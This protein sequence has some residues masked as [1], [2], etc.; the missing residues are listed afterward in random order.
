MNVSAE[1][2]RS[3]I[4]QAL[5]MDGIDFIVVTKSY[6]SQDEPSFAYTIGLYSKVGFELL[7]IG[8]DPLK[9]GD[10]IIATMAVAVI[11]NDVNMHDPHHWDTT[12]KIKPLLT[13]LCLPFKADSYVDKAILYHGES[14][15][16]YQIVVPDVLGN[17]PHEFGY[18]MPAVQ[19]CLYADR[20]IKS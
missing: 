18:L 9:G 6:E 13:K 3:Q 12:E 8:V 10:K 5:A 19:P 4:N 1:K 16:V 11:D 7:L 17:Y 15:P 20:K 2:F 14:V